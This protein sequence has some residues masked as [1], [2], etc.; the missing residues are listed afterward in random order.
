MSNRHGHASD[1]SHAR[2]TCE[3]CRERKVKCNRAFPSCNRCTR[4]GFTCAYRSRITYRASQS[5]I[6]TQLQ[7]RIRE[8][9]ALLAP[10]LTGAN[11]NL[12]NDNFMALQ[13]TSSS[14]KSPTSPD[15]TL[16]VSPT[17]STGKPLTDSDHVPVT[18]DYNLAW[19]AGTTFDDVQSLIPEAVEMDMSMGMELVPI[20]SDHHQRQDW[21]HSTGDWFATGTPESSQSPTPAASISA[22]DLHELHRVF[23]NHI[24]PV[25]PIINSSRFYQALQ[26]APDAV[27]VKSVSYAIALLATTVPETLPSLKKPCYALAKHYVDE[28]ELDDGFN[29]L[30]CM[31]FLQALLLLTRFEINN[32]S[33]ARAWLTLGRAIRLA[34]IMRL[35]QID[36]VEL[37]SEP[38]ISL[39]EIQLPATNDVVELEERRRCFWALYILEG[40]ACVYTGAPGLLQDF[41]Q[42]QVALPSPGDLEPDFKL[43]SLPIIDQVQSISSLDLLTPFCGLVLTVSVM[44]KVF[45]HTLQAAPADISES[46]WGS[47]GFWD[48][49]YSLLKLI[50]VRETLIEPMTL[51]RALHSDPVAFNVYLVFHAIK[52]KLYEAAFE[53]GERQDLPPTTVSAS[54]DQLIAN[55]LKI[56]TAVRSCWGHQRFSCDNSSLS[57]AFVGW[58]LYIAIKAL[59]RSTLPDQK[60]SRAPTIQMLHDSLD[61]VELSDGPWHRLLSQLCPSPR[62][63]KHCL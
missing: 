32:R 62:P 50:R 11:M 19:L 59:S 25:M 49:H 12:F 23:F 28:C 5:A 47:P 44:R 54:E 36:S 41:K 46:Q 20:R 21:P 33:C 58:P 24:H 37:L 29:P 13:S 2:L 43:A 60:Q 30:W 45:E 6:I 4:L 55:A 15:P 26:D 22:K 8:T 61:D 31:N 53:E 16:L 40:L 18:A 27:A 10:Q 48:R 3:P 34:K 39:P 42:L 35:D 38:N 52:V 14:F 17:A 56:A 7:E 51:P 9:E 63:W 57:G 1:G